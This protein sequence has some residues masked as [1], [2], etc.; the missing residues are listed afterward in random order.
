M[1]DASAAS[2]EIEARAV[3]ARVLD[4][5]ADDGHRYQLIARIPATPTRSL[6]WL[7]A[8]GT[9]ARHYIAFAEALA[10]RGIAVFVHEWR[11]NGASQLRADRQHDWGYRELLDLDIPASARSACLALAEARGATGATLDII[12]GHS[13]G[14]QL[15]CCHLARQSAS[16]GQRAQALWLVA[17]GA[18]YWRAFPPPHRYWLPFAYR[19]LPWLARRRGALPGRSIGF[20]GTEAR[21]LIRDW[22]GTA[23][24]GRYAAQGL[25]DLEAG[26]AG[27]DADVR[28]VLLSQDWLAPEGSLRFLLSKLPR[29]TS[30]TTTLDAAGLQ[31]R[32]DHYAWM[33]SPDAV[34]DRLCAP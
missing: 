6:L 11:G 2:V 15:A 4:V 18:P 32:P 21:S 14:G 24:S 22:A 8:L 12:G 33:K 19:F 26:L 34:A 7:P 20:G 28:A 1:S 10:A 13:L 23:L 9:A 31:A 16:S 17:S 3:E 27:I 5:V 29:A 25:G 30:R